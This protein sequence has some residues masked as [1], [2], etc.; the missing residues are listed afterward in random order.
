MTAFHAEQVVDRSANIAHH[1]A[2]Q[3]HSRRLYSTMLLWPIIA[4]LH[5]EYIAHGSVVTK[6]MHSYMYS[7]M[8]GAV[9]MSLFFQH[10]YILN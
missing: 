8:S 5:V 4:S 1:R 7:G 2:Q 3:S 10:D 6:I 9:S